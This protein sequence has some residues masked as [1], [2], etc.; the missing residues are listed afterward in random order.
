MDS[1]FID[2]L[3]K[4]KDLTSYVLLLLIELEKYKKIFWDN[5]LLKRV[6]KI[7]LYILYC[8]KCENKILLDVID[9][10]FSFNIKNKIVFTYWDKKSYIYIDSEK[11]EEDKLRYIFEYLVNLLIENKAIKNY[12]INK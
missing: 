4:V 1:S 7:D 12:L 9:Y 10:Y 5:E 3:M 8:D 2:E 6:N 11:I